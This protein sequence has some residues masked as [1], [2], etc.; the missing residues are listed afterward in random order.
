ML[1]GLVAVE[2]FLGIQRLRQFVDADVLQDALLVRGQAGQRVARHGEA[3]TPEHRI[4]ADVEVV[5]VRDHRD[6]GECAGARGHPVGVL[7][8]G[9]DGDA[10]VGVAGQ[11]V[12]HLQGD[13]LDGDLHRVEG[14]GLHGGHEA[15]AEGA[16]GLNAGQAAERGCRQRENV[17]FHLK[18]H[19][20]ICSTHRHSFRPPG[21][22]G[23]RGGS[24][25]RGIGSG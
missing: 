18:V 20:K 10:G 22:C 13:A 24:G 21:P 15:A 11:F 25:D 4:L 7:L 9:A 5:I 2:V 19:R 3:E 17:G 12:G 1:D 8:D 23:R 6:E 16:V 14:I